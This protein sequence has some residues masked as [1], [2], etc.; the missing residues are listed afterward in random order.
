MWLMMRGG[1]RNDKPSTRDSGITSLR[2]EVDQLRAAHRR[3]RVAAVGFAPV[4]P[5]GPA[6]SASTM[7]GGTGHDKPRTENPADQ[8]PSHRRSGRPVRGTYIAGAAQVMPDDRHRRDRVAIER[9][10]INYSEVAP[11]FADIDIHSRYRGGILRRF[12]VVVQN[13]AVSVASTQRKG[14]PSPQQA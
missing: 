7:V 3:K 12:G 4:V 8:Q 14:G 2:A 5:G 6:C 10:R 13:V 9:Q 11:H 1:P